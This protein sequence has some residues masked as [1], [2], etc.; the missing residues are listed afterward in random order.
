[1]SS[2]IPRIPA[3]KPGHLIPNQLPQGDEMLDADIRWVHALTDDDVAGGESP[4]H[5]NEVSVFH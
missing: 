3:E 2:F 4:V 1:M 5:G